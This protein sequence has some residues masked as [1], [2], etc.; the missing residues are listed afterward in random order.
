MLRSVDIDRRFREAYCRI[1][2][3]MEAVSSSKT[4]VNIYQTTRSN[5]PEDSHLRFSGYLTTFFNY[6]S[7]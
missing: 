1:T 5:I 6:V 7:L 3:M 4:F 2:L